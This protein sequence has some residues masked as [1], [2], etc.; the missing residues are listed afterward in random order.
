MRDDSRWSPGAGIIRRESLQGRP[1]L[2]VPVTV[3]A[4]TGTELAVLLEPGVAWRW[5]DRV[6]SS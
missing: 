3:V 6:Q 5:K 4:D 2:E 1:W